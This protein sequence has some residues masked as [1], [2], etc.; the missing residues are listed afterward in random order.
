M[1]SIKKILLITIIFNFLSAVSTN[2]LMPHSLV[3][4]APIEYN[5]V[6][7]L[8]NNSTKNITFES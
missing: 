2:I 1:Q 4:T 5:N 7:I 8:H 3:E 6:V